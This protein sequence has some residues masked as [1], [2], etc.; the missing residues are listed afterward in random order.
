MISTRHESEIHKP[1]GPY[2]DTDF[3]KR[4]S[5]AHEDAGFDRVLVAYG[6]PSPDSNLVASAALA[7]T[8]R[9]GGVI[10]PRPGFVFPPRAARSPPTG[11]ASSSRPGRPRVSPPSTSSPADA[12]RSMSSPAATTPSSSARV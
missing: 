1:S 10:A 3:V 8:E 7:A 4:F 5:R 6:S 12:S 2:V 11:P 9:L